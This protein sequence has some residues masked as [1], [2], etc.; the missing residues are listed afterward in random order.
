MF[1]KYLRRIFQY[2]LIDPIAKQLMKWPFISPLKLTIMGCLIGIASGI[3]IGFGW[4]LTG[5][6]LL[7]PSGYF[8]TLDGTL[9][10]LQNKTSDFGSALDIVSDRIVEFSVIIGLYAFNS[11]VSALYSLLMLG[12][13]L[14]CV[15]SFL[16]VGIFSENTGHKSFYYSPGLIERGEA[17]LFFGCMI[18]LPS[19]F[20]P[21]AVIFSVLVFL[22]AA[23]RLYQF[24]RPR[25]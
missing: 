23:I 22:T 1:E 12:S 24:S 20:P 4:S 13:I 3:A 7:F 21:L 16:V 10:R 19:I 5:F 2:L 6:F 9:A 17:F 14:I 25:P 15:T 8:D 18:L 11:D